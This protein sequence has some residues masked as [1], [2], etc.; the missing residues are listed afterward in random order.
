MPYITSQRREEL[1]DGGSFARDAGELNYVITRIVL[2]YF[3]W[4][5]RR[6]QQINDV[7]G[8]LESCKAEFQR[9]IVNDYEDK[10]IEEN[11]DV[12]RWK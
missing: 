8:A 1:K 4:N 5:G 12:Y 11:G 3:C 6:Y 2:E 7:V 10:K 9:R